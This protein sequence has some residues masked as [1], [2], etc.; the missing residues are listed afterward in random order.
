MFIFLIAS[1]R[2]HSLFVLRCFNDCF[3]VFF[4]WLSIF[5]FQRRNWTFGCLAYTWGLGTKMS[6]L[7][8][9]PAVGVLLLLGRGFWPSL[10]LA[11]IMAQVQ[12]VIGLPF[13]MN[14]GRGYAARAFELSREFKFE[15][16][17]NWRMLGEEVF[18]SK[19]FALFLLACHVTTLLI[20]I[21][22]RWLQP[23]GRPLSALVP[24]FL[25]LRS[26]YLGSAGVGLEHLPKHRPQLPRRCGCDVCDS[27]VGVSG[28]S[29]VCRSPF[30]G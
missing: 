21:S 7:L 26:P 19:K 10:R 28:D 3:A 17:V 1:K 22:Q 6:L 5:F 27:R 4:L 8:V 23:T 15:W 18:L 12:F 2:L 9:L 16:T 30:S 14:N 20:F 13:I 24:S 11:W 25:R 29:L